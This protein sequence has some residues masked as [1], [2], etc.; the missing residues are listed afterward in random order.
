MTEEINYLGINENFP[1]A[2]QDNDTQTFRDNFDTIKQNFRIAKD[3]ITNLDTIT[4]GLDL[5]ES[6]E[7][8]GSDFQGRII[9]NAVF[10]GCRDK[11]HNGGSANASQAVSFYAGQFQTF[12][13]NTT[14]TF[15]F[16]EF[17]T[18]TDTA[19]EET[20]AMG[21]TTIELKGPGTVVNVTFSTGGSTVLKRNGFPAPGTVA[22]QVALELPADS[23]TN[24]VLVEV[25]QYSTDKVFIK[26][27]GQFN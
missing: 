14:A 12:T 15:T 22:N 19:I 9:Y 6:P 20:W 23:N 2:G 5:I 16:E 13:V 3:K 1:V 7:G 17:P 10:K 18:N 25:W 4:Q 21:K 27:L 26:Y 11:W 24:P 8:F